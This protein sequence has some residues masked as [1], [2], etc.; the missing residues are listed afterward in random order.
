[1]RRKCRGILIRDIFLE[2]AGKTVHFI[3]RIHRSDADHFC[4]S[5]SR[6]DH[7]QEASNVPPQACPAQ[8][9]TSTPCFYRCTSSIMMPSG[10]RMIDIG[11]PAFASISK[12][13]LHECN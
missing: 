9:T 8:S 1:M 6:R 12:L 10:R 7:A 5:T 2:G 4:E 11:Q 3:H 13:R